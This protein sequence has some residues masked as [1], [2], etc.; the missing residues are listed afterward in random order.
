MIKVLIADDHPIVRHGV[1]AV[2]SSTH[3]LVLTAEAARSSELFGLLPQCDPDILLLDLSLP[4]GDGIEILKNLRRDY[5][6]LP[7]VI[8][9]M[10]GEEQFAIRA[11]RAGA[12]GYVTKDMPADEL[13]TAIRTVAGG[14]R[15]ITPAVAELLAVQVSGRYDQSPHEQLSDREFQVLRMI[16]AGKPTRQIA[17]E[18]SLSAKTVNTYRARILE[19]MR[20]KSTAE[21]TAYVVRQNL[22]E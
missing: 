13:I 17:A 21:L 9:T 12:S 16:A 2:L 1:R 20:M 3:D 19:K 18:L 7:V 11:F 22:A 4:D 10:H 5:P 15:H 6:K 14:R 8:L